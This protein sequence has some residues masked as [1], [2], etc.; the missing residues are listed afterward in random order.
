MNVRPTRCSDHISV[1]PRFTRASY[2]AWQTL[3]PGKQH[4]IIYMILFTLKDGGNYLL[5]SGN[6]QGYFSTHLNYHSK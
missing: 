2:A 4:G 3:A 6:Y 5:N 1:L